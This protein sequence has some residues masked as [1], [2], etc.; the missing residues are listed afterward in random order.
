MFV[1]PKKSIN[2]D[3]NNRRIYFYKASTGTW[4]RITDM[5]NFDYFPDDAEVGDCLYFM[6]DDNDP[7]PTGLKFN[8][9][10]PLSATSIILELDCRP[11]RMERITQPC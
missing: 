7:A 6:F 4:T 10:T 5:A 1:Y 3:D 9:G 2:F 8:V 11:L